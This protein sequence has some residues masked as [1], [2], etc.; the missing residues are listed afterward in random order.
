MSLRKTA[1]R[2]LLASYKS[3]KQ[4]ASDESLAHSL[5]VARET[6][7]ATKYAFFVSQGATGWPSARL[8]EPIFDRE[9]GLFWIG[10]NPALRKVAE[11]RESPK[12]TLAYGN[13]RERA[14]L[15][16]FGTASIVSEPELRRRYWKGEWRM[17]FPG[18]PLGDDY[19][20]LRIEP[21][22]MEVLS[23]RRDVVPEPFGLCPVKLAR[24]DGKWVID[25]G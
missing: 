3:R 16:V 7:R 23:F 13:Q 25:P 4:R 17:F 10:T 15:V 1:V 18:G 9:Q 12:V 5:A 2:A 19:V 8:V 22:R 24:V 20:L 14:N 6:V 11:V 21:V